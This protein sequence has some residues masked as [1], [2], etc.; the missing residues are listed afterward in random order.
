[1]LLRIVNSVYSVFLF[2]LVIKMFE[3]RSENL[4]SKDSLFVASFIFSMFVTLIIIT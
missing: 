1:M 2:V 3:E 4:E